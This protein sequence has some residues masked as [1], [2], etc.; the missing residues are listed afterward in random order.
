[1]TTNEKTI[2]TALCDMVIQFAYRTVRCGEEYLDDGGLYA[3]ETAFG[4]LEDNGA[5]VRGYGIKQ[6]DLYGF[7]DKLRSE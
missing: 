7:M 6:S 3:L 5:C 4:V 2:L 1:M